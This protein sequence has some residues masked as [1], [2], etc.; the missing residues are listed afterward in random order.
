MWKFWWYGD[1]K[2]RDLWRDWYDSSDGDVQARHDVVFKFLEAR[3]AW[4]EPYAKKL[5]DDLVEI[6]I[7]AKVQ[8]RLFGFYWPERLNFTVLIPCTHK[9]DVYDPPNVFD[10][11][12]AR[13][14]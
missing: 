7:K 10:T 2:G 3:V 12:A 5:N 14:R 11:A 4:R 6:I 8:H 1:P 13:I 9:D